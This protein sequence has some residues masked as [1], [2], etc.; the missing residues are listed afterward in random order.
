MEGKEERPHR[1][2]LAPA[3]E[4]FQE[5]ELLLRDLKEGRADAFERLWRRFLPGLQ[6]LV[7]G[8]IR[9]GLGPG[10][11]QHLEAEKEDILQQVM[12]KAYRS[13]DTFTYRGPGS[14]LAWLT[15][16]AENEYKHRLEYWRAG[17][18]APAREAAP[19]A[20]ETT[21]VRE[22]LLP[23]TGPGPATRSDLAE[24]RER[25][26]RAL[27]GLERRHQE[28]LYYRF[29]GGASWQ[30]LARILDAP[31]PD[32]VRMECNG[33]ALPALAAALSRA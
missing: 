15:R 24:K 29:F 26:A 16:I 9:R 30:E 21:G 13:L 19:P 20:G 4:Q 31:S 5:T 10:M 17:R 11:R 22:P 7:N 12:I 18:R 33:K 2:L 14:V 28:I 6:V 25:V 27:A 32:A 8:R 3:P 1:A 23:G